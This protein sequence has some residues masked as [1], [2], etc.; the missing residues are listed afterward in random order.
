MSGQHSENCDV[1]R[2]TVHCY[3]E[4]NKIRRFPQDQSLSD[5]CFGLQ[6]YEFTVIA[7]D[8]GKVSLEG[9]AKVIVTLIDVNDN[10]PVFEPAKYQVSEHATD[11]NIS[12]KREAT[13]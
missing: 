13:S 7:R 5:K 10:Q 3:R 4:T 12:I 11:N 9:Y 1:K 8:G 2:K 6:V